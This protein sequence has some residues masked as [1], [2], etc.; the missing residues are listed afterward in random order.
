MQAVKFRAIDPPRLFEPSGPEGPTIRHVA[1]IELG[2]DE[3]VTVV[4]GEGV[5]LDLVR[6]P[7]GFYP[8][9]S[10]NGRLRRFGLFPALVVNPR[11]SLYLLLVE[12]GHKAAFEAYLADQEMVVLAWLCEEPPA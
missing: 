11:G 3:Q 10:L 9:P 2:E 1:D 6:K 5:E 8:M 7:W 12:D 4:A